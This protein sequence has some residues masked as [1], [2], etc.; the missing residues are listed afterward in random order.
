[1]IPDTVR[2]VIESGRLAHLATLN[3]DGSPQMS[4]IWVGIDDEVFHFRDK[5]YRSIGV[6]HGQF[7][8]NKRRT[9][10]VRDGRTEVF[11]QCLRDSG[12][13]CEIGL[14]KL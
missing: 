9:L 4:C 8:R 13:G 2:D 7:N 14:A 3:R 6:L 12:G 1:M 5:F 11:V 10:R